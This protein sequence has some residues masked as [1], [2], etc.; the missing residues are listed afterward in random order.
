MEK[1]V[2]ESGIHLINLPPVAYGSR[3]EK[4]QRR[5]AGRRYKTQGA[6]RKLHSLIAPTKTTA[7]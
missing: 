7:R 3:T 1:A 4:T 2:A 5:V 6:R